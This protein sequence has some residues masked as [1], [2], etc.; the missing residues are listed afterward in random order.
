MKRNLSPY[1]FILPALLVFLIFFIFPNAYV[2]YLSLHEL[3]PG[4]ELQ[5][6]WTISVY[7]RYQDENNTYNVTFDL[8]QGMFHLDKTLQGEKQEVSSDNFFSGVAGR[9]YK[10]RLDALREGNLDN[11]KMWIIGAENYKIFEAVSQALPFNG[12]AFSAWFN[13]DFDLRWDDLKI[14]KYPIQEP[15]VNIGEE[16]D[17][18]LD[19]WTRCRPVTIENIGATLE[20]FQIQLDIDYSE[21]MRK[22]FGDVRLTLE[23]TLVQLDY[24]IEKYTPGQTATIWVRVPLIPAENAT[25]IYLHYGNSVATTTSNIHTTFIFGDDFEN[26]TWTEEYF[27]EFAR[28]TTFT[29][30]VENGEYFMRGEAGVEISASIR[31]DLV[32][33]PENLIIEVNVNVKKVG[34]RKLAFAFVGAQNFL[35]LFSDSTFLWSLLVV[36][37]ISIQSIAIQIPAGLGLALGL[38]KAKGSRTFLTIF[39]LPVT[40]S[41]VTL[42]LMWRYMVFS[43]QGI[44]YS[45]LGWT[46]D[47]TKDPLT[48]F[49]AVNIIADWIYIGLYTLIFSSAL[50]GIPESVFDAARVDG[51]SGFKTLRK[52]V[53]PALKRMILVA[54]IMCISGTFKTFD[55]WW[56][57]GGGPTAPLHLPSTYLVT[58]I[59]VGL[60]GYASTI[61]VACFFICLIVVLFQLRA[62]RVKT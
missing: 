51:L 31:G 55:T 56:V 39:F 62:M 7:P 23:N 30:G 50:K 16:I 25:T 40:I 12:L 32:Q 17:S 13:R 37:G 49:I 57:L 44:L 5:E 27:S 33:L 3:K 8:K 10:L 2:F 48:L 47:P 11:L 34:P 24:W 58:K 53:M 45:T 26:S 43:P 28:D 29:Q 19:N 60:I 21:N 4:G 46:L 1:V 9:W 38:R 14:R 15:T 35:D 54:I 20:N 36:A 22:D 6:N 59:G 41:L 52:I 18:G 61:A 42:C